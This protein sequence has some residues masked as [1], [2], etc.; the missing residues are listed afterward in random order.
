MKLYLY[1]LLFLMPFQ[2]FTQQKPMIISEENRE[3]DVTQ[4]KTKNRSFRNYTYKRD[5]KGNVLESIQTYHSDAFPEVKNN[6]R[7][8][9]TY[10]ENGNDLSNIYESWMSS[11]NSWCCKLIHEYTY[12][13][14]K[15]TTHLFSR[16]EKGK[17]VPQL[18]DI[19]KYDA[20]GN[21]IEKLYQEYDT[22]FNKYVDATKFNITYNS[23][24]QIQKEVV[25]YWKNN[26]WIEGY[27]TDYTYNANDSLELEIQ[28]INHLKVLNNMPENITTEGWKTDHERKWFY[29]PQGIDIG[30]TK[31]IPHPVTGALA[32]VETKEYQ[33][34]ASGNL[35]AY[36]E[37]KANFDKENNLKPSS[38]TR[39]NYTYSS[40]G[41][42]ITKNVYSENDYTYLNLGIVSSLHIYTLQYD[43][44]VQKGFVDPYNKKYGK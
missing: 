41:T 7:E 29:N 17:I 28:K 38:L 21:R 32:I 31:S 1:I 12:E 23:K 30:N 33:H 36:A 42:T 35:L 43:G 44:I 22:L 16:E 39:E 6:K 4:Q 19:F 20:A 13:G 26:K 15:M 37:V 11:T 8:T 14:K 24:N 34:D 2:A 5:V 10:D 40:D 27:I 9:Y 18:K 3:I 25:Y